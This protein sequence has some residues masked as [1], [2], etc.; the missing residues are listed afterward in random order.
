M[1]LQ[2]YIL[3]D[4]QLS[5]ARKLTA[6]SQ[7]FC[8]MQLAEVII[9]SLLLQRRQNSIAY[10]AVITQSQ[11]VHRF[12]VVDMLVHRSFGLSTKQIMGQRREIFARQCKQYRN[13]DISRFH[14]TMKYEERDILQRMQSRNMCE[15]VRTFGI[16]VRAYAANIARTGILQIQFLRICLTMRTKTDQALASLHQVTHPQLKD[17]ANASTTTMWTLIK[18]VVGCQA[19]IDGQF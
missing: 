1:Q 6:Y 3:E 16:I 5:I 17:R 11:A 19:G 10:F 14:K 4:L 15:Q 8:R 9:A 18:V 12:Q 7:S 13:G 2:G